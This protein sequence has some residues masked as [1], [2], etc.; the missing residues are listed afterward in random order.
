MADRPPITHANSIDPAG[1]ITPSRDTHGKPLAAPLEAG[2][3]FNRHAPEVQ[4]LFI[5]PQP[6]PS[7]QVRQSQP[8][9][10]GP[11][12]PQP[13]YN[14]NG[15]YA[16]VSRANRDHDRAHGQIPGKPLTASRVVPGARVPV[17]LSPEALQRLNKRSK[18]AWE[19]AERLEARKQERKHGKHH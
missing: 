3:D 7:E 10:D 11:K 9:H 1:G 18:A 16:H 8:Q 17:T 13:Y 15:A 12:P 2:R 19:Q 4:P 14:A 5:A 6:V